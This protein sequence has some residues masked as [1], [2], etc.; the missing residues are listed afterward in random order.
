[1]TGYRVTDLP[2]MIE[3]DGADIIPV[4]DISTNT[5]RQY[6]LNQLGIGGSLKTINGASLLGT[7][8]IVI[9]QG[10]SSTKYRFTSTEGQI[11]FVCT[12]ITLAD[13]VVYLNGVE[14]SITNIHT[15]EVL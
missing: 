1:M 8:D 2:L 14:Q 12:G 7:G 9:S 6:R 4:V 5:T 13:P 10:S 11:D 15:Q 3:Y